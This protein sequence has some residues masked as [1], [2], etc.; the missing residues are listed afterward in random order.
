MPDFRRARECL[1]AALLAVPLG[2][3]A[4]PAASAAPTFPAPLR[5]DNRL[6]PLR[7]GTQFVYD[8]TVLD[9]DG[10]HRHRIVFTV[11]DMVKRVDGIDSRVIWD[12][13]INDGELS[14][15]ELT[16]FA[17]DAVGNVWTL[18]EYPE[19][20]ENERF[21]GAP[22]TWIS[23]Q[24][25]AR[26]GILVPGTPVVEQPFVQGRAPSVHFYDVG[27]PRAL[28]ARAC[29]PLGCFGNTTVVEETAP[30][31]PEDGR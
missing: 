3:A 9:E 19:E 14:E 2:V 28:R 15:A 6:Y 18:G 7:P 31:V 26:R 1:L 21:A 24:Q 13:D 4:I 8:G 12:Q 20:Y 22:S 5:I 30:L 23:G 16:F 17:Q 29:T 27:R 11:T 10:R 25:G